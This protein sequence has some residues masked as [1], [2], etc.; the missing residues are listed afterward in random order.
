MKRNDPTP[1]SISL[2]RPLARSP[3]RSRYGYELEPYI[4][5]LCIYISDIVKSG[6]SE[7]T[8]NA[9]L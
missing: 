2:T 6:L 8:V 1:D 7:L 3:S 4:Q 9:H 5:Y